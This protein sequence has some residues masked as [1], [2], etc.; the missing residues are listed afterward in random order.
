[1]HR[2]IC[3][4]TYTYID[5]LVLIPSTGFKENFLRFSERTTN[6]HE[7]EK[8]QTT[9]DDTD[10]TNLGSARGSCAGW[11]ARPLLRPRYG[12]GLAETIF[13]KWQH[14]TFLIRKA[15][16]EE[17]DFR[18]RK[19]ASVGGRKEGAERVQYILLILYILSES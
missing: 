12:G 16:N 2:G 4:L 19:A 15:G 1:V 6:R 8:E 14:K 9:T 18:D 13:F 5:A 11:K 3:L 17:L 10:F 7:S